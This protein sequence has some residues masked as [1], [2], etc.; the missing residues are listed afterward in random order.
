MRSLPT[1]P[2]LLGALLLGACAGPIEP[3]SNP[4]AEL[5]IAADPLQAENGGNLNGGNLNGGNLNGN[6]LSNFVV[7]VNFNPAR[8]N[9]YTVDNV[10]LQGT[11]FYGYEKGQVIRDREFTGVEFL[12]NLGDGEGGTVRM[13]IAGMNQAP[14][15]NTDITLYSVQYFD[16]TDYGWK[17][18][19]RDAAGTVVQAIPTAGVWNYQQ[20]V[21]GGGSKY[22]DPERFTFA[23]LGGAIAKCTLWGY[24][25]WA[26]YNGTPLEQYHQACTRLVRADYCGNGKTYTVPGNRI[27]LF[28]PLGIQQD[29]EGWFFEAAWDVNGAK[30]FYALNRT[31]SSL[32][33][34]S[35]RQDLLCGLDLG[36]SNMGMLLANETPGTLGMDPGW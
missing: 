3:D 10:W 17:P 8:K 12:G 1:S 34:F 30:C 25:P 35:S 21:P 20:D 4:D 16:P 28:D 31:H 7:S 19:C 23:C 36:S 15:P 5:A 24:R 14:A 9:G 11:T 2:W 26:S 22:S 6:D 18:A 32:P 33:C 13:R 27:N 29:T